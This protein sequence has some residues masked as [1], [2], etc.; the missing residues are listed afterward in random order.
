MSGELLDL[1]QLD[2]EVVEGVIALVHPVE[3]GVRASIGLDRGADDD[4]RPGQRLDGAAVAR[5]DGGVEAR[6]KLLPVGHRA[7]A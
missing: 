3:Q 4:V 5:V 2:A 6:G 1:K 7:K